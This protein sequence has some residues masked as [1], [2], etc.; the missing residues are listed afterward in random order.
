MPAEGRLLGLQRRFFTALKEPIY[1]HSRALSS[2]PPREG[3]V[4]AEFRLTAESLLTPSAT[5]TAVERLELYH[6][7]YWYRLLDTLAEDFPVLRWLLGEERF[8]GLFEAYLSAHPP[9]S[10]SMVYLGDR[11]A[12]FLAAHPEFVEHPRHC[13]DLV[14]LEY[15][16]CAS[17]SEA[18]GEPLPP[19]ELAS[20]RI[21][22]APHVLLVR[23]STPADLLRQRFL[24]EKKPPKR[25][26][27][28][29]RCL[30]VYRQD[31]RQEVERIP[32]RAFALLAAFREG[33]T[34]DAAF[35]AS[36]LKARDAVRVRRWFALWSSRQWLTRAA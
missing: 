36:G 22:L 24:A 19:S 30:V 31:F 3:D 20:A 25:L 2:L 26:P 8:W 34:L 18:D 14:R 32:E 17:A 5:L 28:G 1:G 4:S 21:G 12:D 35:E 13:E 11:L 15:A 16:L 9:T 10:F 33:A 27:V 23:S 7:Q 29:E 6:R